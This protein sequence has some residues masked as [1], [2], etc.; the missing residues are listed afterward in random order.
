M[1]TIK[2]ADYH[3]DPLTVIEFPD[4]EVWKLRQPLEADHYRVQ[5]V[6]KAHRQR[7]QEYG[8]ALAERAKAAA[9]VDGDDAG[10]DL[11][12]REAG[13]D[14]LPVDITAR[15]LNAAILATF[16]EPTQTPETV[17]EK[18][19]PGII[20]ELHVEITQVLDGEAAKKKLAGK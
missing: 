13:E 15:H 5:E 3:N 14:V 20:N 1:R 11:I 10:R 4:G 16:I 9:E 8:L 18:L 7:A 2:V 17:L 6:V 19:G 12:A